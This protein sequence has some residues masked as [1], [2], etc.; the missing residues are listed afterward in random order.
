[1][2]AT[3][4]MLDDKINQYANRLYKRAGGICTPSY[5][6]TI[7]VSNQQLYK[8]CYNRALTKLTKGQL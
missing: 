6:D 5:H 3:I 4:Q 7:L 2:L 1:M 8:Q